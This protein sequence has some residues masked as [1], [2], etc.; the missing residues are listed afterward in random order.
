MAE[1]LFE[2]EVVEEQEVVAEEVVEP[3]VV[4][5][6]QYDKI[7]QAMD[8]ERHEKREQQQQHEDYKRE[9]GEK[10]ARLDERLAVLNKQ[11][12]YEEPEEDALQKTVQKQQEILEQQQDK[13]REMEL[14]D[15]L[16]NQEHTFASQTPDYT[17]AKTFYWNQR[18]EAAQE[19]GLSNQEIDQMFAVE[20]Q[21]LVD[22]SLAN[23]R[24]VAEGIYNAAKKAGFSSQIDE[25]KKIA[26]QKMETIEKGQTASMPASGTARSPLTLEDLNSM[27]DADFDKLSEDVVKIALGG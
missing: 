15:S 4:P 23:N 2:E 8:R 11:F 21:Q 25:K 18:R 14:V 27:S 24:N 3:E 16:R 1:D 26:E 13:L 20:V 17:Q 7:H 19:M 10:L 22:K 5:K 6:E 12:G 9:Q